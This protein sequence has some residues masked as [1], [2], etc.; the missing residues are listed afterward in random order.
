MRLPACY[1]L[2]QKYKL[3]I[4]TVEDLVQYKTN[5]L[6]SP[7]IQTKVSINPFMACDISTLFAKC[8]LL[9]SNNLYS[10]FKVALDL[11]SKQQTTATEDFT[12]A[13][14]TT[15]HDYTNN[16]IS[17]FPEHKRNNKKMLDGEYIQNIINSMDSTVS[18]TTATLL[19]ECKIPIGRPFAGIQGSS[20]DRSY[21]FY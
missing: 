16:Y 7:S 4:I 2:A 8:L 15:A 10:V 14:F 9:I 13:G 3:P 19:A 17:N 12:I 21:W 18:N 1:N 6:N 11:Q 5:K 20:R